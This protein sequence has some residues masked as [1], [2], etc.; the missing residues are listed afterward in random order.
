M[1]RPFA[2][3]WLTLREAADI[4][5]RNRDVAQAVA[6]W[7]ALRDHVDVIDLGCGT[8]AN[9]RATAALLPARQSWILVDNDTGL[10]AQARGELSRWADS[11]SDHEA[12]G[13]ELTKGTLSIRVAFRTCDLAADLPA[14]LTAPCDLVTASAL[15]DLVSVKFIHNLARRLGEMHSAFYAVLTHNGVTR[16]SP[17]RPADNQIMA[18]FHRHQLTDK[19]F[20][21]AAGPTAPE[22]LSDQLKLNG[23]TVSEGDSPWQLDARDRSLI[24]ELQRTHAMAV[25]ET[26][27]VD[28]KTVE[29][30]VKVKRAAAFVGHSDIFAVPS[31]SPGL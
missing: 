31:S 8:G 29:A 17:H 13:L 27:A 6:G 15:F 30:W 24:E 14:A 4:R 5:A 28:A 18:A 19:G 3:E 10:L 16:W 23:F 12:S 25:L 26:K 20:G 9:L 2:P 21:P 22:E 1:N 11:A 7:F